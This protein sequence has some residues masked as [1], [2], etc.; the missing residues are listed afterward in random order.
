MWNI[1]GF[2]ILKF[3]LIY[4]QFFTLSL[5]LSLA[6]YL[7]VCIIAG[8]LVTRHLLS[9]VFHI[10]NRIRF[11]GDY[12][13]MQLVYDKIVC[14]YNTYVVCIHWEIDLSVGTQLTLI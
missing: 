13:Q 5:S 10:S 11:S 14:V 9:L 1:N 12:E 4:S 6:L 3:D 2:L 8:L 7:A